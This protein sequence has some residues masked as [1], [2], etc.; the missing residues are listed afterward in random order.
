MQSG[1]RTSS[2]LGASMCS[3]SSSTSVS[4]AS[5]TSSSSSSSASY[6][7]YEFRGGSERVPGAV[8]TWCFK[9]I[10]ILYRVSEVSRQL[11]IKTQESSIKSVLCNQ[12]S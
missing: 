6:N 2:S 11:Q 12:C 8:E 5:S 10:L 9:D 3:S 7:D 4:T 1:L